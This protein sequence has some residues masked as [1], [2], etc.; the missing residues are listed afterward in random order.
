MKKPK[1]KLPF[2]IDVPTVAGDTAVGKA[3]DRV[4]AS[5]RSALLVDIDHKAH[6]YSAEALHAA[7][8]SYPGL[9]MKE[10]ARLGVTPDL[11]TKDIHVEDIDVSRGL[12][13]LRVGSQQKFNVLKIA[14]GIHSCSGVPRH[15]F[16]DWQLKNLKKDQNGNYLCDKD[17]TL[18]N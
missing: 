5:G 15:T 8:R 6:L 18:V 14:V 3:F 16:Y 10:V 7:S 17:S 2:E 4:L 13:R 9:Q 1:Q 11:L 12:A